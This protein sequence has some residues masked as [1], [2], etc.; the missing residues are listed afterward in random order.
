MLLLI[1][2]QVGFNDPVWGKRNNPLF[3]QNIA[4]LL[5]DWRR[6]SRPIIHVQ[7]HSTETLSPL[8][9]N[10]SGVGFMEVAKPWSSEPVITKAVNSAF[11]GTNLEANLR[12]LGAHTV[13]VAGLTT[14]HCVSTSVRMAK[15]LG[16]EV[17]V[18]EDATATFDRRLP[19]GTMYESE[20]VH[21]VSLASLNR[22]FADIRPVDEITR[23]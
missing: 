8:R 3:E 11:I 14:D 20:L 2:I 10:Q 23:N 21:R 17:I 7:H 16:F 13:V 15:N 18:A 19:D 22:E 1:D 9:P 12:E 4:R 5:E 6:L